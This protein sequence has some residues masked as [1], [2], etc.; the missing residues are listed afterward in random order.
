MFFPGIAVNL[1]IKNK[2]GWY[3]KRV[4]EIEDSR[5]QGL[6]I[7]YFTFAA[8]DLLNPYPSASQL[9]D[10]KAQLIVGLLQDRPVAG[11]HVQRGGP[12]QGDDD[13]IGYFPVVQI[14]FEQAGGFRFR[15][16][17]LE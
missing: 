1:L 2:T 3:Y 17:G 14:R 7:R 13:E 5:I 12:V 6:V 16:P 10:E 11:G 15:Q 9:P 8:T 4:Q